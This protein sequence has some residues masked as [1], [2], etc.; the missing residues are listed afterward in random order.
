MSWDSIIGQERA[1]TILAGM[2]GSGRVA[3]AYLFSG[4]DGAGQDPVAIEFARALLCERGGNEACGECRSCAKTRELR[5][6]NLALVFALPAGRN[7]KEGDGPLSKLSDA[8]IGMVREQQR[9]K[10]ENPYHT[11]SVPRSN[12][13]KINSVREIRKGASLAGFEPGRKVFIILEAEDLSEN[14]ANALLKT[15]EEPPGET[16]LLLTTSAQDLLLPTLVSRCQQIR[17]APLTVG[18]IAEAL[19]RRA[20]IPRE[21]ALVIA[22]LSN[23]SY[24]RALDRIH[25]DLPERRKEAIDYLRAALL[26]SREEIGRSIDGITHRYQ[27]QEMEEFLVLLE[28]WLRDA[29]VLKEGSAPEGP[30]EE[31]ES[32]RKFVGRYK[33][34]DVASALAAVDRAVSLVGKNVYIPLVLL[35]LALELRESIVPPGP[36]E[37]RTPFGERQVRSG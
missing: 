30:P 3:H 24:G 33:A 22:R 15:L 8:E 31:R 21:D 9:L 14:S 27:K 12:A 4:P 19:E 29:M 36:P 18:Q 5:H 37:L 23:G 26:P 28:D 2:L 13:I 17:L 34:M 25:S 32:L 11:I 10:A 16:V 6:P 1:K 35:N 7:E 20:G